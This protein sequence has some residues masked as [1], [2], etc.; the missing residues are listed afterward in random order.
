MSFHSFVDLIQTKKLNFV[1]PMVWDDPHEGFLFQ[2]LKRNKQEVCDLVP[3]NLVKNIFLNLAHQFELTFY[4][5]SWSLCPE[6]DAM[7]RIYNY[8]N[9]AIRLEAFESNIKKINSVQILDVT[10]DAEIDLQKEIKNIGLH[11]EKTDFIQCFRVKRKAFNHEQEVRLVVKNHSNV[12]L[13]SKNVASNHKVD[14]SYIP[15]LINSVSL[16]PQAP[17]WFDLTLE[18]Y[19]KLNNIN[20]IG[21]SKLYQS[22]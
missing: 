2:K 6:S 14:I 21:K 5:Q 15:N 16:H 17:E 18:Q 12:N 19:C 22:V 3:D 7:W 11:E 8:E 9:C 4:A 10:Y 1:R 20:Y 13:E